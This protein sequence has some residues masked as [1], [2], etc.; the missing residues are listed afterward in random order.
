M[1]LYLYKNR[2]SSKIAVVYNNIKYTYIDIYKYVRKMT[3]FL[4]ANKVSKQ[5]KVILFG[6]NSIEFII[7]IFAL[8]SIGAIFLILDSKINDKKLK[9]IFN[10][11]SA[12]LIIIDDKLYQKKNN[13]ILKKIQNIVLTNQVFSKIQNYNECTFHNKDTINNIAT[14][15]YTSGSTGNPKGVI[16]SNENIKFVVEKINQR[17][18][19]QETD[20]VFNGL[21]FSF[22]YG[23]YQIFLTFNVGATLILE[24]NFENLLTIPF[25]LNKYKV[26]I[27]PIVP[28]IINTLLFSRLLDRVELPFLS[29]ITSTGEVLQTSTINKLQ[30]LLPNCTIFPMYGI[31]ECKRVTIMPKGMLNKKIGS[32]GKAIDDIKI[33]I[34][35]NGELLV[36]GKNVMLGYWNQHKIVKQ[37]TYFLNG[38][39]HTG[40][41][42]KQDSDGYL[43]FLGRKDDMVK[44][45]SKRLSL[46]EIEIY[47]IEKYSLIK[48]IGIKYTESFLY[49]FIFGVIDKNCIVM[50]LKDDFQINIRENHIF[51]QDT[52]LLKNSNGKIDKNELFRLYL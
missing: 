17:L 48:E 6:V 36:E 5:D 20:I 4:L 25:L 51:I 30:K 11:I 50:D 19:Y 49:I 23:L 31:T 2:T 15:I 13:L 41:Y 16:S 22:D 1:Y 52:P 44:I 46:K 33:T 34:S 7:S 28:T 45:N 24:K 14:I 10:D 39:L 29:K 9:Y 47:F 12:K 27:F 18:N 42:F 35:D 3:E 32:V 37:G 43:Y 38:I 26:T 40:D 8:N 21:N